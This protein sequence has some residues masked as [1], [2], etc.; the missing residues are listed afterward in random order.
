MISNRKSVSFLSSFSVFL[1]LVTSSLSSTNIST[2]HH[3][4]M[5]ENLL[6]WR[7]TYYLTYSRKNLIKIIWGLAGSAVPTKLLNHDII[8]YYPGKRTWYL[9]NEQSHTYNKVKRT[10]FCTLNDIGMRWGSFDQRVC[11]LTLLW[12]YLNRI[13]AVQH[14]SHNIFVGYWKRNSYITLPCWE[15]IMNNI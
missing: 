12:Y 6:L 8:F 15:D 13:D 14:G 9:Q 5:I 11:R 4:L 7:G 3:C 10:E 1:L 2:V